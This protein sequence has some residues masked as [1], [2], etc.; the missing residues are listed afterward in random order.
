[1]IAKLS[2]Q[3]TRDEGLRLKA[4]RD[5]V[6]KLTVGVGHNL[7]DRP[8]SERAAKVILED[9][10]AEAVGELD[11]VLPWW[12]ELEE[13]R[14]GVLVNM[15]FNLG[16]ARLLGFRDTLNLLRLHRYDEASEEMLASK[17]ALQVGPRALRL[18]QQLRTGEWV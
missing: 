3:L 16:A 17:W 14:Q 12:R 6:D 5:S 7:D 1:M 2:A 10:I 18:S 15:M 11:R 4:Y 9:D 8:I 13:P